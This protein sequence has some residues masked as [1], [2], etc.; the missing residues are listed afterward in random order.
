MPAALR[1]TRWPVRR[2]AAVSAV[3]IAVVAGGYWLE[4]RHAGLSVPLASGPQATRV[5]DHNGDLLWMLASERRIDRRLAE[6]SPDLVNAVIAVE[7]RRF[8][9]HGGVDLRRIVGATLANLKAGR[10]V[11][12]GST[13][14]Q[15]LAR[16][17]LGDRRPTLRRKLREIIVASYLETRATKDEILETYLNHIYLGRGFYGAE[18][19]ALGYF[20]ASAVDLEPARA[21]TLAAL[22]HAPSAYDLDDPADVA[23][24]TAR[25]N[26]VLGAM[27]ALGTLDAEAHERAVAT[28][29]EVESR[30]ADLERRALGEYFKAAV[31]EELT[32]RF[33]ADR[34]LAG[35]L[36]VMTTIDPRLQKLAEQQIAIHAERLGARGLQRRGEPL[37]L[38]AGLV[39]IDPAS[40]EVR[41]LVGGR[42]FS[43]SQFDRARLA[44]R[45]PG[46]AF[47]P[48]VYA[49]ALE[50]GFGPGSVLD[51]I[52]AAVASREGAYLPHDRVPITRTTLRE[53]L[54]HSNNRAAVHLLERVGASAVVDYAHKLGIGSD[55]PAVP[56]LAL[57]TG[58]VTLLELTAAYV[59][60]ANG[61]WRR[62]PVLITRIEDAGGQVLHQASVIAAK[63]MEPTTAYLMTS[64]LADVVNH[65][66]GVGARAAGLRGPAAGKTGTTDGFHDAW[67]IGYT[68]TLVAGVWFG[69]DQ[70]SAI[71][72]AG[73]AATVAAPAWGAFMAAADPGNG[74][75]GDFPRPGD[76]V[77]VEIC[78]ESGLLP[79]AGCRRARWSPD[80]ANPAVDDDGERDDDA[81]RPMVYQEFFAGEHVPTEYCAAHSPM[82]WFNIRGWFRRG[83]G[84][85]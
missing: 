82:R 20:G 84:G 19:A 73:S 69:T 32:A 46:S 3:L 4:A 35:G 56:S 70:P 85:S 58:E 54:T 24:L 34:L 45:Q 12:G 31:R 2:I 62:E 8:R 11:E 55:L 78:R 77:R 29:L 15:Q 30:E 42:Q 17:L 21:A 47:K 75:R 59:P 74:R 83:G 51:H 38:E 43:E 5:Y 22:I 68:P 60:F 71:A 13:I 36:R 50:Q 27:A 16:G 33:G 10:V 1:Q 57:G 64:M 61:G 66:T 76:L 41:A 39:A 44:H 53:A 52:D 49:A 65:G 48:I 67:F 7:D 37:R 23:R 9:A 25:R 28:P 6:I 80:D 26:T 18:A 14:T 81:G 63:V 72:R 40:G 79:N